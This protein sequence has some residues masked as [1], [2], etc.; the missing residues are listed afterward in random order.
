MKLKGGL[1]AS[2][3]SHWAT[4]LRQVSTSLLLQLPFFLL[5]QGQNS[6]GFQLL[7][8][9]SQSLSADQKFFAV[10]I[11][12]Q[13]VILGNRYWSHNIICCLGH[14]PKCICVYWQFFKYLFFFDTWHFRPASLNC[15]NEQL[16]TVKEVIFKYIF[17]HM[18]SIHFSSIPA[19]CISN[20]DSSF[21]KPSKAAANHQWLQVCTNLTSSLHS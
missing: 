14:Q 17:S 12:H 16:L 10:K 18:K 1:L 7:L 19:R 11:Y 3:S 15:C 13:I 5:H 6:K 21:H 20:T 4:V 2:P 9:L 8:F